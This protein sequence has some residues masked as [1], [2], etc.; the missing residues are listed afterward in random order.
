LV[1]LECGGSTPLW[2]YW[3][4]CA[5]T[6]QNHPKRRRAA[7]L[8]NNQNV[9]PPHSTNMT[10]SPRRWNFPILRW[11]GRRFS[12]WKLRHQHPVNFILHLFGIPLAVL[13]LLSL[14]FLS[15][16]G[17]P[18]YWGL[19]ALVL[20]YA[21]Q[22]IGHRLEGNDVGELIPLKRLLGLPCVAISPRFQQHDDKTTR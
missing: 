9:E 14:V 5:D 7:A 20:G 4:F 3:L 8:Q 22:L 6:K 15:W 2:L 17:V 13:G 11:F 19:G 21:L 16:Y 18:W 1:V 10:T 12:D